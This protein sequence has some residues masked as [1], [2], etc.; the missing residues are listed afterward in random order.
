M[1]PNEADELY[2]KVLAPIYKEQIDRVC[3]CR[4]VRLLA[5]NNIFPTRFCI[6]DR[7]L[8]CFT[9]KYQHRKLKLETQEHSNAQRRKILFRETIL[10]VAP[11]V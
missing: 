1:K 11:F 3:T 5:Q 4:I 6:F 2:L 10:L 8:P 7:V 9:M